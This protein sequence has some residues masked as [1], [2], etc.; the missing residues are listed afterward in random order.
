MAEKKA[1]FAENWL[2]NPHLLSLKD[3]FDAQCEYLVHRTP[4]V[5]AQEHPEGIGGDKYD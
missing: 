4:L 1:V 2:K 3:H 5:G